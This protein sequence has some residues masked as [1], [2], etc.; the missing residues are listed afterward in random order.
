MH[1]FGWKRGLKTGMYYLRTRPAVDAIKF[2]VDVSA[3]KL[4]E[5]KEVASLSDKERTERE[6]AK[7]VCSLE[8][9][10]ACLMCSG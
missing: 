1:F 2:T 3:L 7:M 9:K 5:A 6:L 4:E 8:N 10:E